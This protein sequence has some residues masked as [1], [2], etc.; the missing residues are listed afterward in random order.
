M[1]TFLKFTEKSLRMRLKNGFYVCHFCCLIASLY[2]YAELCGC[3]D[4]ILDSLQ[5]KYQDYCDLVRK[6][7]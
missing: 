1:E 5:V 3:V 6:K 7:I 2:G 4:A